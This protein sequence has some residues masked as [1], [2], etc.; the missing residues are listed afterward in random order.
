MDERYID[1]ALVSAHETCPIER[2]AERLGAGPFSLVLLFVSPEAD[3]SAVVAEAENAWP[4]AKIAGC[5]TAGEIS[6]DGYGDESIVA[7]GFHAR[8]FAAET[9]L[10]PNL[11]ELAAGELTDTLLHI[12]QALARDHGHLPEEFALL[13]V[14]GLSAREDE[15]ASAL[16]AATGAMPLIGGSA[17]DGTHFR[18]TLVFDGTRLL[19]NAA[20]ISVIRGAC[21]LRPFK[22]DHIKPTERRMVVTEA[23]PAARIVRCIN[24][25]PAVHEYARLI[26]MEP[27]SV[28]TLTFAIHPLTVRMGE[29]HHVRAIQRV[30]PSGEL[31]FF[32][33]IDEGMVLTIAEPHDLVG[34]LSAE[35]QTLKGPAD[36]IAVLAFDC[37][38]R[39]IEAQERQM[40]SRVSELLRQHGVIGFSTYGEQFGPMHINHTMTGLAFYPPGTIV[41]ESAS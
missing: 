7:I 29:R 27:E 32:S 38:L 1:R 14:D 16:A 26:G 40:T 23:E 3:V 28:N 33:A 41:P 12:R 36:P 20:V 39:R 34:H 6:G 35:L 21:P 8:H 5:T 15:L 4:G 24:A 25:E 11:S 17:G 18:E 2:L 9:L 10:V 19:A 37:I 31:L 22:M 30:L 13:F